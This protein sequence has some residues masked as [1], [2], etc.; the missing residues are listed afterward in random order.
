MVL[1]DTSVWSLAVRRRGADLS[2]AEGGVVA[3]WADLVR[4]G[5]VQMIGLIR[6]ELLSGIRS[7]KQFALLESALQAFPDEAL[8]TEDYVEAARCFNLC[9]SRGVAATHIDMLI[10]AVAIRRGWEVFTV[11]KDFESYRRILEFPPYPQR[12]S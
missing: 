6:Q 3:A 10:C 2:A 11:D 8:G 5:R 9:R 7:E 1:V 4:W 12:A